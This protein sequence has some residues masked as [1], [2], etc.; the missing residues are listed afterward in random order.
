MGSLYHRAIGRAGRR[1]RARRSRLA[2]RPLWMTSNVNALPRSIVFSIAGLAATILLI[3]GAAV[4]R[5]PLDDEGP[6]GPHGAGSA[7]ASAEARAALA[8][9]SSAAVG[10]APRGSASARDASTSKP[11][12]PPS[13]REAR[14]Q[15]E[16]DVDARRLKEA[17]ASFADLLEID[18]LA[19]KD[20]DVREAILKLAMQVALLEGPEPDKVFELIATKTGTVGADILYD[21]VAN[22]GGSRA[23]RYAEELLKD[24]SVRARGTPAMRV[25]YD[26]RAA[27]GCEDKIALL[28]RASADGDGR[29]Y[30]QLQTVNRD[31]SRRSHECC[32]RTNPR[33]KAAL[34]AIRVRLNGG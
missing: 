3:V 22:R 33:F 18:P 16:R 25:A 34:E 14:V 26:L 13:A 20:S 29:T 28:D 10:E 21:I 6:A 9:S 32:L 12:S 23:W 24:E 7:S 17:A 30:G 4:L 15:F 8:T 31:C 2:P 11:A 19:P 27:K 5:P 1:G